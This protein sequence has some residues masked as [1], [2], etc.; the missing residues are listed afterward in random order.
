MQVNGEWIIPLTATFGAA[1]GASIAWLYAQKQHQPAKSGKKHDFNKTITSKNIKK[2]SGDNN[3]TVRGDNNVFV[4]LSGI[5]ALHKVSKKYAPSI[6][7]T[8]QNIGELSAK[9]IT[10]E[11]DE[12]LRTIIEREKLYI[13]NKEEILSIA[14]GNL[15]GETAD[16]NLPGDE[17]LEQFFDY[18][19]TAS[20]EK[21]QRLWAHFF[22]KNK[23]LKNC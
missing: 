21:K 17:W 16:P 22:L 1:I 8:P 14:E 9:K 5:D 11:D 18:A 3:T 13:S 20:D 7:I 15:K 19:K 12:I 10:S 23:I 4:S 2:I 6:I